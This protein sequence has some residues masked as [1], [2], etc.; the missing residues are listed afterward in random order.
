MQVRDRIREL[1]RVPAR[2]LRLNP[3]NWRTHP[4]C[5]QEALRALLVEVGY[6]EALLARELP[7][8]TLELIDGHLRAETT[9]DLQV[10]VLIVDV[11]EAE[12]DKLLATLD[13]LA[14]QAGVD[15]RLLA[16]L[17]ER[18]ESEQ[19]AVQRMLANVSREADLP[20]DNSELAA[21]NVQSV[22][23]MQGVRG[24]QI[25]ELYQVVAECADESAQR[26]LYE[27]LQAEGYKC[28]LLML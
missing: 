15:E 14:A 7:D 21:A 12:A 25:K 19:A 11:T 6:A 8:G 18:V 2:Q 22:R 3:R 27:R 24:V 23:G 26:A 9:P 16:E 5:Q 4:Q 10:P 20:I 28:R 17:L 13:P 1:R